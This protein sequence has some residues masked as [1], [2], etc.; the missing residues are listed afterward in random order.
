ML[1]HLFIPII[2]SSACPASEIITTENGSPVFNAGPVLALSQSSLPKSTQMQ[3][4]QAWL[5]EA[6]EFN[7]IHGNNIACELFISLVSR[8]IKRIQKLP[9]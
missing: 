5:R 6:K 3:K 7:A 4:A 8:E 1:L 9:H 2:L